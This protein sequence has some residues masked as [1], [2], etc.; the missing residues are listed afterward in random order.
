MFTYIKRSMLTYYL[1]QNWYTLV[2]MYFYK[3][4]KL[5]Y[6]YNKWLILVSFDNVELLN[7]HHHAL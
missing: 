7:G 2:Q 5:F 3:L 1:A 4:M 6:N